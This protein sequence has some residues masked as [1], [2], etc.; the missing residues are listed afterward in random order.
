MNA[1]GRMTLRALVERDA[2]LGGVTSKGY[3]KG[4]DWETHI[5]ALPCYVWS[6]QRQGAQERADAVRTV[7]IDE[8][9][10]IVPK[11]TDITERDRVN[12]VTDRLGNPYL[13]GILNIR[14]VQERLTHREL[15]LEAVGR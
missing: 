10:M 6:K 12:G 3:A 5:E 1:R 11:G 15:L 7:V 14:G 8:I 13:S 9:R 4:A 2:N